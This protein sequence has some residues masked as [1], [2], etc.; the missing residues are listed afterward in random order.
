MLLPL[1]CQS[2]SVA[3]G[4]QTKSTVEKADQILKDVKVDRIMHDLLPNSDFP[5]MQDISYIN[6]SG[7]IQICDFDA[8]NL[9]KFQRIAFAYWAAKQLIVMHGMPSSGFRC[10]T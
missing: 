6:Y 3:L 1:R 5:S 7:S 4:K 8:Y 10:A 2:L 9:S